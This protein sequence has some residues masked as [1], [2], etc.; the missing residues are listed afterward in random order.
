MAAEVHFDFSQLQGI[1]GGMVLYQLGDI[2]VFNEDEVWQVRASYDQK[3]YR[4]LMMQTWG[5]KC[6]GLSTDV[7]NLSL[8]PPYLYVVNVATNPVPAPAVTQARL[9]QQ[10]LKHLLQLYNDSMKIILEMDANVIVGKIA[11]HSVDS[12]APLS[13]Q[14]ISKSLACM[15]STSSCCNG[16]KARRLQLLAN[17]LYYFPECE[18]KKDVPNELTVKGC[19]GLCSRNDNIIG[20]KPN[21][22]LKLKVNKSKRSGPCHSFSLNGLLPFSVP[23]SLVCHGRNVMMDSVL[24]ATLDKGMKG[25]SVAENVV[26][27]DQASRVAWPTNDELNEKIDEVKLDGLDSRGDVKVNLATNKMDILDP[28]LLQPGRKETCFPGAEDQNTGVVLTRLL[29]K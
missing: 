11:S 15:H 17:S 9:H 8:L 25:E 1:N 6:L 19:L 4:K 22:L 3:P 21:G 26:I 12:G 7:M 28:D 23:G 27:Y 29:L 20:I 13:E 24:S 10:L 16:L 5:A 2:K 18:P 14:T